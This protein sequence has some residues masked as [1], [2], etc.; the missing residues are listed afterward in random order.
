MG[1]NTK[2]TRRGAKKRKLKPVVLIV[3]EG[4]KTEPIY[5]NHFKDRNKNIQI[6]LSSEGRKQRKT[7]YKHIVNEAIRFIDE[8]DLSVE[9]GDTFWCVCDADVDT[10]TPGAAVVK[11]SQLAEAKIAADRN[12]INMIFSNPCFELWFLLHF[13]YTTKQFRGYDEILKSLLKHI[14]DYDK[15]TSIF[16]SVKDKI[17]VASRNSIQLS[18]F[19][20]QQKNLTEN[21]DDS[22]LID[23]NVVPFTNVHKLI[24]IIK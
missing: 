6:L 20:L 17:D 7:D 3:S 1:K 12:N 2:E 13:E 11:A 10:N 5:F 16:S 14:K 21:S 4:S 8:N 22:L 15:N 23:V 24:N 9:D 19:Q 18:N